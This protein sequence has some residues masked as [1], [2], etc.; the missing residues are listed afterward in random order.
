IHRCY[1][2]WGSRK[3]IGLPLIILSFMINGMG[4]AITI[5]DITE[6]SH[7]E[8]SYLREKDLTMRN[9]F[10][11]SNAVVNSFLT[12]M[13]GSFLFAASPSLSSLLHTA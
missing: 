5:I 7:Q 6:T 8:L 11:I 12:L 4:L 3:Q 13:T 2:I 9:V 1:V 10:D